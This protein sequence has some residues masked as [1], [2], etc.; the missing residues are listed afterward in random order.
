MKMF[1]N[2]HWETCLQKFSFRLYQ[3]IFYLNVL[4]DFW[5]RDIY[6]K[7]VKLVKLCPFYILLLLFYYNNSVVNN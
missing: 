1:K 4:K 5:I 3:A 2:E 6:R 7:L